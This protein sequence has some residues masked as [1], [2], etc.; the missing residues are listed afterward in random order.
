MAFLYYS[1]ILFLTQFSSSF[2][3]SQTTLYIVLIHD[4]SSVKMSWLW[5]NLKPFSFACI[6]II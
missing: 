4:Y 5:I 3:H 2:Y 1:K 6:S